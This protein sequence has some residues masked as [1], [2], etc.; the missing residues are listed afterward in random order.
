MNGINQQLAALDQ[1]LHHGDLP[2]ALALGEKLLA[3]YPDSQHGWLSFSEASR[4]SGRTAEA[5]R[6][7]Q[8]AFEL[9]PDVL[10]AVAQYALCLVPYAEHQLISHLISRGLKLEPYNDWALDILASCAVSIDEWDLALLLY[11]ILR[12][13]QADN[14]HY[15][16]MLGLTLSVTGRTEQAVQTL[17]TICQHP[18]YGGQA[19]LLI[20][21]IDASRVSQEALEYA[22]KT[23]SPD[24]IYAL[25]ALGRLHHNAGRFPEAF[26]CW[27]RANERKRAFVR[28]D[29]EE[30]RGFADTLMSLPLSAGNHEEQRD[31]TKKAPIFIVGL[32]RSG[33]TLLE[34]LLVN[35][36]EVAALGEL[37]DFEVLL[38]IYAETSI[39][40][41]PFRLD[42]QKISTTDW[43]ALGQG[44]LDRIASRDSSNARPCDKNPFNFLFCGL[45]LKALPDARIIH[46][47]KHPLDAGLGNF[48]HIFAAAAPWSYRL[49]DIAHFYQLYNEIMSHWEALFPDR[50]YTIHYDALVSAPSEQSRQLFQWLELPWS[51]SVTDTSGRKGTV[52]SA[53]AN[54]VRAAIHQNAVQGWRHYESELSTLRNALIRADILHEDE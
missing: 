5:R 41:L 53:S 34:R 46:I 22:V 29:H 3:T 30:W 13:R 12:K 16:Y 35:S 15:R 20:Q 40:Q 38:Q 43:G 14:V 51:E 39:T 11:E 9:G 31:A 1:A 19:L 44:Y 33:T 6:A 27:Q 36:G 26:A 18:E 7:S 32:P 49:E 17:D 45:I 28:Y 10:F 48:R 2:R 24:Q 4:R 25:Q 37:R 21:D 52:T 54:Q 42:P 50:I 8:R 23:H 47:R